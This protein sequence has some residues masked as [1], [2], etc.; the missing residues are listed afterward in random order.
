MRL[1]ILRELFYEARWFWIFMCEQ[2][3]YAQFKTEIY[4]LAVKLIEMCY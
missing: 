3:N 1:L 2:F 4:Q